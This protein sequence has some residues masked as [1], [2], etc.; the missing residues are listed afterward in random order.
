MDNKTL[1]EIE[2]ENKVANI[3]VE[4]GEA[5][6]RLLDNPDYKKVITEGY[7][8]NYPKELGEAIA[9]NTGGY[10]TDKLIE[11]L[12]GIN[13][14]VGYTFQVAANHT[15]AEKTLIDNA[16]FIAQEGDSDE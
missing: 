8:A 10:D 7:L 4:I 3:T 2:A 15:A 16:K 11:N 12:K 5:L 6:K 13:T 1:A 14:F 9:K